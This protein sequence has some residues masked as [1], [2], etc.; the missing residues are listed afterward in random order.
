MQAA[1]NPPVPIAFLL[2]AQTAA[3]QSSA[4][5]GYD[6]HIELF[7]IDLHENVIVCEGLSSE[8][9]APEVLQDALQH[10]HPRSFQCSLVCSFIQILVEKS[11]KGTSLGN[12]KVLSQSQV[13]ANC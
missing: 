6:L 1:T 4:H 2:W 12:S 10:F 5:T 11:N 13:H 3:H 7:S 9:F 8:M